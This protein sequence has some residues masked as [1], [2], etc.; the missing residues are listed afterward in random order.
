LGDIVLE[1][2][3]ALGLG[4]GNIGIQRLREGRKDLGLGPTRSNS[5]VVGVKGITGPVNRDVTEL[6]E[7]EADT[8][9]DVSVWRTHVLETVT[10][11]LHDGLLSPLHLGNDLLVGEGGQGVVRPGVGGQVVALGN[12]TLKGVGVLDGVGTNDE[13][14]GRELVG[15]E[16]VQQDGGVDRGTIVE[17]QTPGVGSSAGGDIVTGASIASPVALVGDRGVGAGWRSTHMELDVRGTSQINLL[18]PGND[19]GGVDW[20]HLID[21]GIEGR[22]DLGL[23][24]SNGQHKDREGRGKELDHIG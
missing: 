14:G 13:E 7:D 8:V 23:D 17:G 4:R 11:G 12:L 18:Q 21:F 16:V 10:S 22:V 20:G 3:E 5:P 2:V 15:L 6:L 19:L 9:V 1:A 24:G